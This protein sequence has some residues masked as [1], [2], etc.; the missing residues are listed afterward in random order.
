MYSVGKY[1]DCKVVHYLGNLL[2]LEDLTMLD[3]FK[4]TL[5]SYKRHNQN[6][7]LIIAPAQE[8]CELPRISETASA[9]H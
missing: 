9:I 7:A 4:K 1:Q 8:Q 6:L 2:Y 3:L 5:D